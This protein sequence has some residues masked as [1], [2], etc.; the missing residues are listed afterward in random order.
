MK[1]NGFIATSLIYSFFLFFCALLVGFVAMSVHNKTLVDKLDDD[2]KKELL[3]KKDI[4]SLEIG[5]Y[6]KA[7][8]LSSYDEKSVKWMVYKIDKDNNYVYLI[9]DSYLYQSAYDKYESVTTDLNSKFHNVYLNNIDLP[10]SSLDSSITK[11]TPTYYC[12][13]TTTTVNCDTTANYFIKKQLL[14]TDYDVGNDAGKADGK[15]YLIYTNNNLYNYGCTLTPANPSLT[16]PTPEY[17]SCEKGSLVDNTTS[18]LSNIRAT[19]QL[20]SSVLIDSGN[21]TLNNPYVLEYYVTD[22]LIYHLS[23]KNPYG[24][25]NAT[26]FKMVDLS[27][28]VIGEI[29]YSSRATSTPNTIAF[30]SNDTLLTTSTLFSSSYTIELYFNKSNTYPVLLQTTNTL[31]TN[32]VSGSGLMTLDLINDSSKKDTSIYTVYVDGKAQSTT[33]A[34]LIASGNLKISGTISSIRI[35]NRALTQEEINKNVAMDKRWN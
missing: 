25:A 6:V 15:E 35:Y 32:S 17:I 34:K 24:N 7:N 10:N 21:G 18:N 1:K 14:Y 26:A 5:N 28:N 3:D 13:S 19:I 29:S 8:I 2:I 12:A 16:T 9:S 23:A 20:P 30:S 31:S 4:S 22:G 33:I 27:G 11:T